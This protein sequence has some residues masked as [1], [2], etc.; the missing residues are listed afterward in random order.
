MCRSRRP[1][2]SRQTTFSR[3][4]AVPLGA[5]GP[6]G[7]PR[8]G[9]ETDSS[10]EL[11][12]ATERRLNRRGLDRPPHRPRSCNAEFCGYCRCSDSSKRSREDEVTRHDLGLRHECLLP[13]SS[14]DACAASETATQFDVSRGSNPHSGKAR[15]ASCLDRRFGANVLG[16][17]RC[18]RSAEGTLSRLL[19]PVS[20]ADRIRDE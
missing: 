13:S 5:A 18:G 1:A 20:A 14:H 4:A 8:E 11:S 3:F 15:S 10:R 2:R 12:Q 7:T 6:S 17:S 19:V 9:H 16:Q